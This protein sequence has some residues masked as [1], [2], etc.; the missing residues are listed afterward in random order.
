MNSDASVE[1]ALDG[2]AIPKVKPPWVCGPPLGILHEL[3]TMPESLSV[4][5]TGSLF[6]A[7]ADGSTTAQVSVTG[8]FCSWLA[9]TYTT[10]PPPGHQQSATRSSCW[11]TDTGSPRL[12]RHTDTGSC[13]KRGHGALLNKPHDYSLPGSWIPPFRSHGACQLRGTSISGRGRQMK[14]TGRARKISGRWKRRQPC[15]P[16]RAGCN[17]NDASG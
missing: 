11:L 12:Y 10:R 6:W 1:R 8:G 9:G 17:T 7:R 5:V 3:K 14:G 13:R 4:N 16:S 15:P 2:R